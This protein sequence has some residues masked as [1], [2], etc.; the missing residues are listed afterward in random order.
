MPFDQR[1]LIQQEAWFPPLFCK[2]KSAKKTFFARRF[3]TIFKQKCSNLRQLLS[4]T[5]PQ[6]FRISKNIGNSTL[7]S[8]VKSEH[9]DK[10]TNR[11]T[12]VQTDILTYR[13][14]DQRADALKCRFFEPVYIFSTCQSFRKGRQIVCIECCFKTALYINCLIQ[15]KTQCF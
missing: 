1:S 14:K 5:F 8:G 9:T 15:N 13:K 2:A 4:I 12:H 10:Q 3:L 6:G 11:Q 7:G